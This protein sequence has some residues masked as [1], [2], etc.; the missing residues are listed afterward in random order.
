MAASVEIKGYFVAYFDRIAVFEVLYLWTSIKGG[1]H[2]CFVDA[3][4]SNEST[5][6]IWAPPLKEVQRYSASKAVMQFK[7]VTFNFYTE[8]PHIFT[9]AS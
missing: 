4:I 7:Y 2:M 9:T 3:W 8:L 1:A 6:R 5:K